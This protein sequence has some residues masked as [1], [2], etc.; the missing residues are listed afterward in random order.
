MGRFICCAVGSPPSPRGCACSSPSS[1]L[2]GP[3]PCRNPC[4]GSHHPGRN[5]YEWIKCD[6]RRRRYRYERVSRHK[7]QTCQLNVGILAFPSLKKGTGS[8]VSMVDSKEFPLGRWSKRHHVAR[9]TR[10]V[11]S[12]P[13][14]VGVAKS[15]SGR[16]LFVARGWNL[17]HI[18]HTCPSSTC[19]ADNAIP[20]ERRV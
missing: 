15:G 2:V 17:A 13:I 16:M 1:C 11:N 18:M 8:I 4:R 19:D 20:V 3:G 7:R 6:R 9:R 12:A 10:R 5:G 14:A